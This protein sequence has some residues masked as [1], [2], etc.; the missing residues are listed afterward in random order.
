M[1]LS[2]RDGKPPNW[3]RMPEGK[4]AVRIRKMEFEPG[5]KDPTYTNV[6]WTFAVTGRSQ[7]YG[8][9]IHH[10][11]PCDNHNAYILTVKV[12]EAALFSTKFKYGEN[13]EDVEYG[14]NI[15]RYRD[16]ITKIPDVPEEVFK[17]CIGMVIEVDA[18]YPERWTEEEPKFLAVKNPRPYIS[19]AEEYFPK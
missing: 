2:R 11:T 9:L 6:H 4:Y 17:K 12:L 1:R 3:G 13:G 15:A 7:F 8:R 5:K 10:W 18:F 16:P 19:E 14:F